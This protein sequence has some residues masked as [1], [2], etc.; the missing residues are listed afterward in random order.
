MPNLGLDNQAAGLSIYS[1]KYERTFQ[2][3]FSHLNRNAF[4]I[5]KINQS[6]VKL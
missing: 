1:I 6:E 5:R 4:T 3:W 2:S